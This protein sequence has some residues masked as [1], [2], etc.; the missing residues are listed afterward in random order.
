MAESH[1]LPPRLIALLQ[2]MPIEE[3]AFAPVPVRARRDG[4]TVERQRGFI[5]RLALCGCVTRAARGLG[6]TR[7]SAYRLLDRPG[8]QSFAA[9]WDKALGWG[10]DRI[11]DVSLEK[12]LLGERIPIVRDGRCVGERHRYDN[13]LALAVLNALD[14]RTERRL[15]GLDPAAAFR[16]ALEKI[17]P[18]ENK[19]FSRPT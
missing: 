4:W 14:R 10:R 19:G 6:M 11:V 3:L 7:K 13:R 12:A 8:S 16:T 17:G 18:T 15:G 2:D 5:L 9:A 1:L